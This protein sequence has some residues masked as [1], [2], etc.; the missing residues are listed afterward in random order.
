ME[1]SLLIFP[2]STVAILKPHIETVVGLRAA[3]GSTHPLPKKNVSRNVS[4]NVSNLSS[5]CVLNWYVSVNQ[6]SY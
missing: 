3:A 1:L 6:N 4:K 5:W 2:R